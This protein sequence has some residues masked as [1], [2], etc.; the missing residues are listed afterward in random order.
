MRGHGCSRSASPS[1]LRRLRAGAPLSLGLR[2]GYAASAIATAYTHYFGAGLVALQCLA[3]LGFGRSP[4]RAAGLTAPV[5]LAGLPWLPALIE[6]AGRSHIWIDEP[7][8]GTLFAT[9][10]ALFRKPGGFAW[11]AGGLCALSLARRF[12]A[13]WRDR[14]PGLLRR[15]PDS[16]TGLMLAWLLTPVVLAFAISKVLAP[17]YTARNLLVVLP[18]AYAL[19]ARSLT[20]LFPSPRAL[21]SVGTL[22]ALT[23]LTGTLWTGEHY[24]RVRNAQ[25]RE[26]AAVVARHEAETPG[27]LVLIARGR[28]DYFD[29]YLERLGARSRVD[30]RMHAADLAAEIARIHARDPE[31][32]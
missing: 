26:A 23:L 24:T 9:W 5:A 14:G 11:V 29:Y 32:I 17:I 8:L 21:R 4:A 19:F 28:P 1:D 30:L 20:D 2:A 12:A 13:R 22:L 27:A 6:D 31:W 3:L 10:R 7:D 15:L 18:A 16:P 25:F